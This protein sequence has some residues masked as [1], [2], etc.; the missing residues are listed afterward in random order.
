MLAQGHVLS[1][2]YDACDQTGDMLYYKDIEKHSFDFEDNRDHSNSGIVKSDTLKAISS[3]PMAKRLEPVNDLNFLQ[4]LSEG[5]NEEDDS[6]INTIQENKNNFVS[7]HIDGENLNELN[8]FL[9]ANMKE[10]GGN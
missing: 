7:S 10:N 3:L 4:T 5:T 9:K 1:N 2:N 8:C 6:E